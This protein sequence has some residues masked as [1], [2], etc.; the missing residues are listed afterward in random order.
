[1]GSA[2]SDSHA[3][4]ARAMAGML[5]DLGFPLKKGMRILDF[6]CGDGEMVKTFT[7]MGFD[8]YGVDII[9]CPAL[10]ADHYSKI[11]FDP[12]RLPFEDGFF[13]FVFSSSVF[14]HAQNTAECFSEIHRVLKKGGATLHSL[15]SPYR[16]SEAHIK[17]PFGGVIQ[18]RSWLKLW[19][20]LGVRNEF[21]KG[22]S[23]QETYRRNVGYCRDGLNY[24]SFGELKK[25]I[26]PIFGNV[27]VVKKEY[28]DHMPGGAARLG[29]KLKMPFF[30]D[31]IFIFR[32]WEIFMRKYH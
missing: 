17:V 6:G 24:H 9:D 27:K 22:L 26:L 15:P 13:D 16:L 10:D 32:E 20:R 2:V 7:S 30:A 18:S 23:W 12:Y 14:E 28:I 8:A 19:A 31:L 29:R 11:G 3:V 4:L 5:K 25:I 1:M 21:Q